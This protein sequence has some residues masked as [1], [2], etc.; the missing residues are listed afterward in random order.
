ME[1][2]EG[3]VAVVTGAASGIGRALADRFAAEGMKVV[4]ADV[5]QAPLD[6]AVQ[7]LRQHERDVIGVLADVRSAEAVEDLARRAL[8]A[9]GAVHVVCNNAG[10]LAAGELSGDRC[11]A[12]WEQPLGDWQWTLDVNLWGVLHGIRSFVP[13]MLRQN[14]EGH[15]VNTG[16]V[17]GLMTGATLPAYSVSKHAV[18]RLSEALYFQLKELGVPVSA[19]VLCPGGVDTGIY[20]AERNRPAEY[21]R[22]GVAVPARAGGTGSPPAEIADHVFRAI[23]DDRFYILTHDVHE[24]N[25]RMRMES[26]LAGRNPDVAAGGP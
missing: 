11:P 2:F 26:I 6:A 17:A 16:S 15:I 5:E 23:R 22:P 4:L 1:R 10:V 21:A 8:D 13:I 7:E 24:A 18:V 20:A 19:S 3:R 25:V 9:Y 12:I 14:D